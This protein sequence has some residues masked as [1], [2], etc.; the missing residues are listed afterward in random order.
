MAGWPQSSLSSSTSL[1]VSSRS[2]RASLRDCCS[3]LTST[4]F[5]ANI[6]PVIFSTHLR[7]VDAKPLQKEALIFL[8]KINF[9][10]QLLTARA[11]PS[12]HIG[13]R[14]RSLRRACCRSKM[15]H[16]KLNLIRI[17]QS[18]R[19]SPHQLRCCPRRT[20]TTLPC[21][22][23]RVPPGS[24]FNFQLFVHLIRQEFDRID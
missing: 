12:F 18:K 6:L 13:C 3:V 20:E 19:K 2:F 9:K 5:T 21:V 15:H 7:T 23:R 4:I 1:F 10:S 11:R 16:L 8:S 22:Y 14:T 24:P 17:V